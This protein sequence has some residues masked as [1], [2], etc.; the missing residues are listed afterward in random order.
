[1]KLTGILLNAQDLFLFTDKD[2]NVDIDTISQLEWLNLSASLK[3]NKPLSKLIELR[4]YFLEH[5][6][7]IIVLTEL[8]GEESLE[9]FNRLFLKSLYIGLHQTSNS[10]RGIDTGV[11]LKKSTGF[12]LRGVSHRNLKLKTK[13]PASRGLFEYQFLYDEKIQF[14]LF[15]THL[16]SKLNLKGQDFEGR[17]QREAEVEAY[18]KVIERFYAKNPNTPSALLGDLNGIIYKKETEPEL[19]PFTN[20]GWIDLLQYANKSP[21]ERASY[22]YFTTH[23]SRSDMQLDYFLTKKAFLSTFDPKMARIGHFA[24]Q[25]HPPA[26]LEQREKWPSD[27]LPYH[28][29][30]H[31]KKP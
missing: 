12:S 24:Q 13:T 1:M 23:G 11:L 28:F 2:N 16:K 14:V 5:A 21:E 19:T 15:V 22:Y 26:T 10:D 29:E 4:D 3:P 31:S 20:Y 8:G 30:I 9:N 25:A 6:P 17:G 7:D 27:H 18:L